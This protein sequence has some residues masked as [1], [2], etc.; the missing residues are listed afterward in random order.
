LAGLVIYAEKQASIVRM[1]VEMEG[2]R[3]GVDVGNMESKIFLEGYLEI[4]DDR[5]IEVKEKNMGLFIIFWFEIPYPN[6]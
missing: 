2:M 3:Q 4:W 1:V 6:I 5:S